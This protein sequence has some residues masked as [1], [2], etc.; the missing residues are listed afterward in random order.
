MNAIKCFLCGL[1]LCAPLWALEPTLPPGRIQ[2]KLDFSLFDADEYL[3]RRKIKTPISTLSPYDEF[4]AREGKFTVNYGWG[5]GI[6][7]VSE[8]TWRDQE[9]S[10]AAD[11]PTASGVTGVYLA[12]RQTL[13]G[14][15]DGTRFM[16]ET[17]V[18]YPVEADQDEA[19][20]FEYEALN[21]VFVASY[22]QDFFPTSG[23]FEMDLGYRFRNEAPDDEYFF[24]T[25]LRL[26]VPL[27]GSLRVHY[28][29]V[30]SKDRTTTDYPVTAYPLDR[31]SQ[32]LGLSLERK[33]GRLDVRVGYETTVAGRNQFDHSGLKFGLSWMR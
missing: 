22:N 30:E 29:V 28:H 9:L 2:F 32:I 11:S 20:A 4:E 31:G 15:R 19:F 24:D 17:G 16:A 14:T 3:D 10:G 33:I 8:T 27:I 6:T 23:G 12:M 1:V 26:N 7:L 18:W 25:A 5:E 13:S 21:W